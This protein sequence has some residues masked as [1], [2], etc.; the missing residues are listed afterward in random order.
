MINIYLCHCRCL[1]VDHC[2]Y[3]EF[4]SI[5]LRT[6]ERH[7]L[8]FMLSVEFYDSCFLHS[9]TPLE[10]CFIWSCF[11]CHAVCEDSLDIQPFN[12]NEGEET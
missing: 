6:R 4:Y 2:G 10:M 12:S 7:L 5:A 11:M 1:T 9:H 8:P 3:L